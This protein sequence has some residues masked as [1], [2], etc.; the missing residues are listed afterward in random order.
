MPA[1]AADRAR[2][3]KRW[4]DSPHWITFTSS[5]TVKNFV[6]VSTDGGQGSARG[7]QD[8]LHRADHVGDRCAS[9]GL[10]V[11]VEADPHTIGGLVEALSDANRLL[12][13]RPLDCHVSL[14]SRTRPT[15]HAEATPGRRA[16]SR[17][18]SARRDPG[19]RPTRAGLIVAMVTAS[20]QS[21]LRRGA[22]HF[23]WRDPCADWIRPV[24]RRRAA[25]RASSSSVN[26]TCTLPK[27]IR[28]P[29]RTSRASRRR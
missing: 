5:S 28:I 11:D 25:P 13:S 7:N 2:R 12:R 10:T 19:T 29:A 24:D 14:E 18:Q 9:T 22:S 8:R 17:L 21:S 6:A 23:R 1:D 20:R 15:L 3:K 26:S 16:R 4:R 27:F